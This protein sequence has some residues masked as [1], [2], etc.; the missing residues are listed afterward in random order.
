MENTRGVLRGGFFLVLLAINRH[1]I[2]TGRSVNELC[3]PTPPW[4][5]RYWGTSPLTACLTL[6]IQNHSLRTMW[7]RQLSRLNGA[8]MPLLSTWDDSQEECIAV[9][10]VLSVEDTLPP[11][12]GVG[13]RPKKTFVY[14]RSASNVN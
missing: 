4:G 6:E 14:L 11:G 8:S 2:R 13:H 10:L 1:R 12:G 3:A 7:H 5:R 9:R